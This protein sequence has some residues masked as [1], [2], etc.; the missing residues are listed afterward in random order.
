MKTNG[1]RSLSSK[2]W[3]RLEQA[4]NMSDTVVQW[5]R[6][7]EPGSR[8][9]QSKHIG[10]F[11]F[12]FSIYIKNIKGNKMRLCFLWPTRKHC[13]HSQRDIFHHGGIWT[14]VKRIACSVTWLAI[15]RADKILFLLGSLE[16]F[17]YIYLVL[18]GGY[19]EH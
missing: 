15:K 4:G 10:K 8:P 19:L 3:S 18:I 6:I 13:K 16:S 17:I 9:Q 12:D 5:S 11:P 1:A 14:G 7:D 2:N